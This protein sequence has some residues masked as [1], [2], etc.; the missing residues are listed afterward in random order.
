LLFDVPLNFRRV[1]YGAVL[2]DLERL[3]ELA[4]FNHSPDG[5]G[6]TWQKA[7]ALL[8]AGQLAQPEKALGH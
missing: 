4:S 2:P 5:G 3:R 6:A 1:P 8:G 7:W